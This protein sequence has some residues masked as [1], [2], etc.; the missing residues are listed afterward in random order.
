[1]Q[2]LTPNLV[3]S[4]WKGLSFCKLLV[5]VFWFS[6]H[7]TS[8]QLSWCV[9]LP[10]SSSCIAFCG[11]MRL[12]GIVWAVSAIA[13]FSF[14]LVPLHRESGIELS[15]GG[16]FGGCGQFRSFLRIWSHHL[17]KS[18]TDSFPRFIL[19]VSFSD[20]LLVVSILDIIYDCHLRQ[21][22]QCWRGY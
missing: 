14:S 6:S 12:W 20:T 2:R 8:F 15:I 1:M 16:F 10:D 13:S 17:N 22:L 18:L 7:G 5:A 9:G 11:G 3:L 19:L 21:H 4:V